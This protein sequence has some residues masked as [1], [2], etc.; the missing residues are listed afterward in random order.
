VEDPALIFARDEIVLRRC[1]SE[2]WIGRDAQA[3]HEED[4]I[5]IRFRNKSVTA[6]CKPHYPGKTSSPL[7][8]EI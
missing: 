6:T 8:Q 1:P 4:W 2:T 3:W 5:T 7:G